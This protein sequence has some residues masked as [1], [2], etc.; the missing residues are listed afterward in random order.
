MVSLDALLAL[1]ASPKNTEEP[2]RRRRRHDWV[3]GEVQCLMCGRLLGRL[4]GTDHHRQSTDQS[5]WHS[6]SFFAYRPA[7]G[8]LRVM[9]FRPGMRFRC[10]DCGGT[11]ALDDVERFSTYDELPASTQ[12]E[13]P[14]RRG[15][16]RPPRPMPAIH[17][18]PNGLAIALNALTDAAQC[19]RTSTA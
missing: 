5:T 7:D 10:P 13:E 12:D 3:R 16:G 19:R 6:A 8:T 14:V 17:P 9:A 18:A 1:V 11:G 2:K 4:L 15:P